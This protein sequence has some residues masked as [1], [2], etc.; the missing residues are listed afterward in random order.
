MALHS[1]CYYEP[2]CRLNS[3]GLGFFKSGELGSLEG[4]WPISQ[5]LE[6]DR[7]WADGPGHRSIIGESSLPMTNFS[8]SIK[9]IASS[10]EKTAE[11]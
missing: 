8:A 5:P 11:I 9:V 2:R 4:H 6:V 3:S 7:R 1:G 10:S